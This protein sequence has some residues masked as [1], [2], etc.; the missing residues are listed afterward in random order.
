MHLIQDIP[1][2]SIDSVELFLNKFRYTIAQVAAQCWFDGQTIKGDGRKCHNYII[3]YVKKESADTPPDKEDKPV[4]KPVVCLDPGHGPGCANGSLD[5][6]YKE[7]EFT[8]KL[9]PGQE[10]LLKITCSLL[11]KGDDAHCLILTQ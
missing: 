11:N 2:P 8:Q 6:S 9:Y 4:S 5:G 3:V 7:C 10:H 1:F